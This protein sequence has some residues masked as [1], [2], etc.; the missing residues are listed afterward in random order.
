MMQ[1]SAY[2]AHVQPSA[3]GFVTPNASVLQPHQLHFQALPPMQPHQLVQHQMFPHMTPQVYQQMNQLQSV[4]GVAVPQAS[5]GAPGFEA[6][7]SSVS[8]FDSSGPNSTGP[9]QQNERESLYGE[10]RALRTKM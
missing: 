5:P 7:A 6:R 3:A 2:Q 1:P 10:I 4:Q 8:S 9:L